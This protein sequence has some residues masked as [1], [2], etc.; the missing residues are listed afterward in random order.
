MDIIT[1]SSN[2]YIKLVKSLCEK[3]GREKTGL[4][5]LEG[6][7]LI[8]DM[9]GNMETE[10][11][12]VDEK[13]SENFQYITAGKKCFLCSENAIKA[14]SDTVTPCGIIAVVKKPLNE[15]KMPQGNAV[16]L[17]GVSDSGNIGTI[18]RT[19][20]AVG[21]DVYLYNSADAYSP[22]TVRASMSAI[23]KTNIC[24]INL[25]QAETLL[26]NT[27][28]YALDMN[29]DSLFEKKTGNKV[30]LVCGNEA[31]GLSDEIL[32]LTQGKISLPMKN[33]MESLNV[34]VATSVA[35]YYTIYK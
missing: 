5:M 32:A 30:T 26:T 3:K 34:A 17:D 31:H 10:F 22:K 12:L 20:A 1:S 2:Q 35:M 14:A 18:I 7:R 8:K 23:F 16:L 15:F 29:G 19:A 6:E 13:K 28:S 27:E 21:F 25:K 4:F 11:F 9:P 24:E 33:C